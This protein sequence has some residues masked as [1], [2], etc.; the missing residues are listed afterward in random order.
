MR[1]P[2]N[3]YT[4]VMVSPRSIRFAPGVLSRLTN[5]TAR[6]PGSSVSATAA[7]FVDEGL[8]MEEQPGIVFRDGPMG[9]RAVLSAGPDV[10]EIVREAAAVR[11][12]KPDV[13]HSDLAETLADLSGLTVEKVRAALG[14]YAAYPD[15]ID[16][17]VEAAERFES[18]GLAAQERLGDLRIG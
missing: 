12:G 15:E 18:E 10:W 13:P 5:Y 1:D 17:F 9:R 8:R 16:A 14:Y 6:H 4:V 7:R 3:D 11:A 2:C